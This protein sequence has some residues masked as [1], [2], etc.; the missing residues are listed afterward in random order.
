[1]TKYIVITGGV[2]SSL[3]KGITAASLGRLLKNRGLKVTVQKFDP[4]LNI[5]PGNMSPLQHG[6]VFVT[7][8]GAETDLDIGHYERFLDESFD[9]HCDY[10]SG[11]I[12]SAVF[13]KE[14]EGVYG[15]GTVQVVPHVTNQIK[16]ALKEPMKK[17][18]DVVLIEIGGTVGDIEGLPYLEA[19]R[20]FRME[21][22]EGN[23]AH[24]HVTLLP[25]LEAAG[26][27]KTKPTQH[28]VKELTSLGL[29]PD[30]VVCRSNKDV[31]M[32]DEM[33]SKIALFC[34]LRDKKYVIHNKD[35]SSLYAVPLLL[36]EQKLDEVICEILKL[37]TKKPN[38]REW[39]KLVDKF[40]KE[41]KAKNVV[42]VGKYTK[43]PDAYISVTEAIKHAGYYNK[44]KARIKLVDCEQIARNG[45]DKYLG[46]A[47]A[48]VVVDNFDD[49]NSFET[50]IEAIKFAR[51]NNIPTLGV[52]QGMQAMAVEY[53]RNV[54]KIKDAN[55]KE[56]DLENKN[57]IFIKPFEKKDVFGQDVI[58]RKGSYECSI[59][60]QTKLYE[61]YK[62]TLVN[63]RHRH[64]FE[65]NLKF[66]KKLSEAGLV[67]SGINEENG[68][69]EAIE[70]KNHRFMVGVQFNPEFKSRPTNPH[71]LYMALMSEIK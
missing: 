52:S 37:K 39:Q 4:Y 6:E 61:A 25:Y 63:E 28:S 66:E 38:N 35:A 18:V 50:K 26:E 7:D 49:K 57:A 59:K 2:V 21:L 71:K 10:T 13:K 14:R 69:V 65:F 55:S 62:E 54:A 68:Y 22:G 27:V 3:G 47:D 20:Q 67:F 42:I 32:N 8:D 53:A 56:F 46:V 23:F 45:A 15:G 31:D 41:Y 40:G 33:K 44:I 24:I 48:L 64:S 58:L 36:A 11:K 43:T 9:H 16:E 70:V 29:V 19:L 17:D 60:S 5:D 34:N 12:Y 30:I 51:E 1:M